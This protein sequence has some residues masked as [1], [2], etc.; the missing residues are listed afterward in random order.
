MIFRIVALV[1]LNSQQEKAA[2]VNMLYPAVQIRHQCY[3]QQHPFS[4]AV[5][6]G[7]RETTLVYISDPCRQGLMAC[8][9]LIAEHQKNI[10]AI[11][12]AAFSRRHS[13]TRQDIM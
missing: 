10:P 12:N 5:Q 7:L 2:S 13:S 8:T 11:R 4:A 6:Q 1:A 9:L 3:Q